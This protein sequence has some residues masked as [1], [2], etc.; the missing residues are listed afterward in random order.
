MN[1]ALGEG[2]WGELFDLD[3]RTGS[4]V[5]RMLDRF[6]HNTVFSHIIYPVGEKEF[7]CECVCLYVVESEDVQS[8]CIAMTPNFKKNELPWVGLEPTTLC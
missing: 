2:V 1:A 5:Y 4:V 7:M 8:K 3:W 6:I